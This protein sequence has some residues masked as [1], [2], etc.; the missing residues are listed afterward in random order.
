MEEVTG[1]DLVQSRSSSPAAPRCRRSVSSPGRTSRCRASPC[2]VASPRI[3]LNPA[4]PD[5]GKVEVYRPRAAWAC[6]SAAGGGGLSRLPQLRFAPH[7][8]HVQGEELRGGDQKMFR[9]LWSFA[10]AA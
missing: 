1:I 10:F 3:L 8:A 4:A 7:Q 5:F 6:A 9:A 2:S